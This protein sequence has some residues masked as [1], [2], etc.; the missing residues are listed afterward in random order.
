MKLITRDTDYAIRALCFIAKNR[1]RLITASELVKQLKI[2]RP[3]L[4]KQLQILN[5]KGI[6]KSYR[7]I[8]GGFKLAIPPEKILLVDLIETFQGPLSLNECIFKKQLCPNRSICALR[9]KLCKIER[10]VISELNAITI[11]SLI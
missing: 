5:K 2:P 4:R 11:S 7:G 1:E 10:R 6:L 3:F 9:H 8:K